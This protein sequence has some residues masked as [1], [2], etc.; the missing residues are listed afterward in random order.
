MLAPLGSRGDQ[1]IYD[2]AS[3]GVVR[4]GC[5]RQDEG[6]DGTLDM[7]EAAVATEHGD[8]LHGRLYRAAIVFLRAYAA[9]MTV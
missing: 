1:L 4:A 2:H 8:G 7:F 6:F 9:E 3:G 5:W